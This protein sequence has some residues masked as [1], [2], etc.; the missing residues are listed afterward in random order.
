[1]GLIHLELFATLD[2]VGH[3]AVPRR[4]RRF[5]LSALAGAPDG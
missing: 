4:T 1:M 5:S 3:P 2:L